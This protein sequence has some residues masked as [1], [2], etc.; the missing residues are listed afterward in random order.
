MIKFAVVLLAGI[1]RPGSGHDRQESTD[2]QH[3]KGS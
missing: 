3:K 1:D 2:D